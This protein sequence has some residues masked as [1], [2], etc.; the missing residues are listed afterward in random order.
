M[1]KNC[2]TDHREVLFIKFKKPSDIISG[3]WKGLLRSSFSVNDILTSFTN[4]TKAYYRNTDIEMEDPS[5]EPSPLLSICIK[6]W[7]EKIKNSS[8]KYLY[9]DENPV[10]N[11]SLSN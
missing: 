8:E 5:K 10:N 9:V 2:H 4:Q 11:L 6:W 7:N 3:D 1:Y